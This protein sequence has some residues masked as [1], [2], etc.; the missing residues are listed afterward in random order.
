MEHILKK[1]AAANKSGAQIGVF[2]VCT[3]N[4]LVIR[5]A[6]RHAKKL[7]YPLVLE[8]TSNQCNQFGGY[9]G[10]MPADYMDMVKALA[11]TED[12]PLQRA[13]LGGDH[14]GPIISTAKPEKEAMQ[15]AADMVY[16]YVAAGFDKIH[17]DT[18]MRL[19]D[20]PQCLP[21]EICAERA[22]I[23]A[24]VVDCAYTEHPHGKKPVLIVGSEVPIPGGSLAHED[25][26]APTE[27]EALRRQI[28]AFRAAFARHDLPFEQVVGFVVQPGVE[29]GDDFVNCYDRDRAA[30]LMRQMRRESDLVLEGHSTDYQPESA[31]C[32]LVQD[33]VAILKVGPALTFALRESLMLLEHAGNHLGA[34][35]G[36][37]SALEREM[38]KDGKYWRN[39][40][41]GTETEIA[42]KRIFSYSDRCRYYLPAVSS[43]IEELLRQCSPLPPAM[44]SLYFPR[45][46]TKFM[47]GTL[48]NDALSVVLDR[49]GDVL[50]SYAA[51]CYPAAERK[52]LEE[53]YP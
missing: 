22:A 16:D 12:Y 47:A 32:R 33:G 28:A 14:L 13:I 40:Y 21:P 27:P 31:L 11:R 36:F 15:D 5:A 10:M 8:A 3:A 24:R 20:D 42:R 43:E 6:M 2:S 44:L 23:L 34:N 4:P 7:N 19:K 1:I 53:I 17:I 9:T 48:R 25:S 18:S 26:V 41:H 49:V 45:Q 37:V 38:L 30:A 52:L 51:A 29:F 35:T 39:Y 50:D 46:Y